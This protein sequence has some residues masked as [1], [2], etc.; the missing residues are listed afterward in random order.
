[1]IL[2]DVDDVRQ[3]SGVCVC[4]QEETHTKPIQHSAHFFMSLELHNQSAILKLLY[5]SIH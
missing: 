3:D 1:M 2:Q 5:A 4:V